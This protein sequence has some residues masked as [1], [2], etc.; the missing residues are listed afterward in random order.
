MILQLAV[1]ILVP[2]SRQRLGACALVV[3]RLIVP[4]TI[5][6]NMPRPES[7]YLFRPMPLLANRQTCLSIRPLSL[8]GPLLIR[9]FLLPQMGLMSGLL[10]RTI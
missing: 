4:L 10:L 5:G 7:D 6:T 9:R 1:G 3:T 2:A 8:T